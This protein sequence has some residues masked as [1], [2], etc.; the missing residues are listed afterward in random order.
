MM[1]G[2]GTEVVDDNVWSDGREQEIDSRSSGSGWMDMDGFLA[3][4]F[5]GRTGV[6][7]GLPLPHE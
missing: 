6:F 4:C 3:D 2:P 1:K 7:T 5:P